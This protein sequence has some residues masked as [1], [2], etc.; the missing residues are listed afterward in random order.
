MKTN[1]K[2]FFGGND[3]A[4]QCMEKT[5]LGQDDFQSGLHIEFL[6]AVHE[7]DGHKAVKIRLKMLPAVI[8]VGLNLARI[9]FEAR[10]SSTEFS[11]Q[12]S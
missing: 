2:E 9:T 7:I 1:L 5:Q 4:M 12:A 10:T 8:K 6:N 3:N 11:F